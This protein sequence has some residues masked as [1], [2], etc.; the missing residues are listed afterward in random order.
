MFQPDNSTLF[1][2]LTI[3]RYAINQVSVMSDM[4]V[5]GNCTVRDRTEDD[6]SGK[7]AFL[8]SF[9]L[10]LVTFLVNIVL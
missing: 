3:A 2:E 10:L 1:T 9:M 8:H 7:V 4:F 6:S 5:G